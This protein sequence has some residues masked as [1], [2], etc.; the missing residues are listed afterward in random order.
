[1]Y[2]HEK[3]N[4]SSNE[5]DGPEATFATKSLLGNRTDEMRRRTFICLDVADFEAAQKKKN[6][7]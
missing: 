4:R 3:K 1:M 7:V 6:E 5:S 2:A